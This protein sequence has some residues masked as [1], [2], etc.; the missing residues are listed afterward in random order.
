MIVTKS[1]NITDLIEQGTIT[2]SG[3]N[4]SD[5]RVRNNGRINTIS[6]EKS[7]IFISAT[8]V[9]GKQLQCDMLGYNSFSS[10]SPIF[11]LYW[12]DTPHGFDVSSYTT[13]TNL[14][15]VIRYADNSPIT[16]QDLLSASLSYEID[17][18]WRMGTDC[19][20]QDAFPVI[21]DV[22]TSPSPNS[23]FLIKDEILYQ[24]GF[25]EL[26]DK[27]VKK[28]YPHALWVIEGEFLTSD[29]IKD[30]AV[31]GAFANAQNLK[32]ARI[33][34]SVKKIG[35]YSFRNTQLASVTIASDCEYYDTSFPD[36]CVINFY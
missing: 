32:V 2:N 9:N 27:A 34:E 14:R 8:A 36:G 4:E 18:V 15:I 30:V 22:I 24:K 7:T 13:L 17:I 23:I 10:T 29:T 21:P 25:P 20:T 28:P 11:D 6:W 3:D 26:P 33:P 31:F 12:F 16:P 19:P 5:I 35:R 1:I